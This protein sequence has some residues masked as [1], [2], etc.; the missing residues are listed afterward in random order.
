MAD[1]PKIDPVTG[2]PISEPVEKLG[3]D[4]LPEPK[5]AG[6]H[7]H[8]WQGM[9]AGG[10]STQMCAECGATKKGGDE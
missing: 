4:G 8:V 10:V 6:N 1:E 3:D 5:K 7:K 2:N 9:R